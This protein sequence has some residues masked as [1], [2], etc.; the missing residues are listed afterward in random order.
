MKEVPIPGRALW[1]V[2]GEDIKPPEAPGP[3]TLR[4]TDSPGKNE[5]KEW[6]NSW[7]VEELTTACR[8]RPEGGSYVRFSSTQWPASRHSRS[9]HSVTCGNAQTRLC[10]WYPA[11]A[12]PQSAWASCSWQ[13]TAGFQSSSAIQQVC[14]RE[15]TA[16]LSLCSSFMGRSCLECFW[17]PLIKGN[18]CTPACPPSLHASAAASKLHRTC[19]PSHEEK[20]LLKYLGRLLVLMSKSTI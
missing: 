11:P 17:L 20:D 18:A 4:S 5:V 13:M 3:I 1:D 8:S 19:C 6:V 7:D 10:F 12:V 14:G 9:A 2:A 16:F 15:A